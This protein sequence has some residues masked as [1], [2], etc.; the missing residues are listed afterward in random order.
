VDLNGVVLIFNL[1]DGRKK[2]RIKDKIVESIKPWEQ[3]DDFSQTK[4]L[5]ESTKSVSEEVGEV[6]H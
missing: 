1:E 6:Q 2:L 5:W 4:Y 3:D